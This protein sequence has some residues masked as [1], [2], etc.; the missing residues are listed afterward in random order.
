MRKGE[1]L[2]PILH[3]PMLAPPFRVEAT[4]KSEFLRPQKQFAPAVS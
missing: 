3:M 4:S 1:I 2:V